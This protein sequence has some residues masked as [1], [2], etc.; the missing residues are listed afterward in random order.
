MS[1]LLLLIVLVAGCAD[2]A[3]P[4]VSG[5]IECETDDDCQK[6]VQTPKLYCGLV[7]DEPNYRQCHKR[8]IP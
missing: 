7:R 4:V 1:K 8:P 5:V 3:P 6:V 2:Y